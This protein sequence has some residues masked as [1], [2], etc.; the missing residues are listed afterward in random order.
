[1][2]VS[3]ILLQAYIAQLFLTAHPFAYYSVSPPDHSGSTF[4]SF[5]CSHAAR[6]KQNQRMIALRLAIPLLEK[7]GG[8]R[9]R[10]G[11]VEGRKEEE[12]EGCLAEKTLA[13][14]GGVTFKGLAPV[15]LQFQRPSNIWKKRGVG[16]IDENTH[17]QRDTQTE[18]HTQAVALIPGVHYSHRFH[19]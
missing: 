17:I 16:S 14:V 1:M 12:E 11:G 3:G 8:R 6:F 19:W 7:R 13:R 18:T 10:G 9:R 5:S 15:L 4:G 2:R